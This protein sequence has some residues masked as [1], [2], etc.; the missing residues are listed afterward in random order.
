[1]T[2]TYEAHYAASPRVGGNGLLHASEWEKA[3]VETRFSFPWENR[4]APRTEFRAL[5]DERALYFAFRVDDDDVVLV[6]DFRSKDDVVRE[7]RAEL[8]FALD[9]KLEKYF[10]LE[11]DPLGRVLDYRAAH[12]RKF[13]RSWTF[14]GLK[15][16]GR[17]TGGGYTVEGM[18][19][20]ASLTSLGFPAPGPACAIKFGIYRAEFR[21]G[22][23]SD[24]IEGWISWVDPRTKEPDF[25]VPESFGVLKMIR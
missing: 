2:K 10:C 15:V 18:I 5:F 20:L 8:F 14:P 16:A 3:N 9:E 13:D 25:H 1:M 24:P 23:G 21:H 17:R 22:E 4:P 11:L 7:D 19:P 6:E 12:Y